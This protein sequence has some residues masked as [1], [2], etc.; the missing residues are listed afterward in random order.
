MAITPQQFAIITKYVALFVALSLLF[1]A[2][3]D[4]EKIYNSVDILNS[5]L[6]VFSNQSKGSFLFGFD[7]IIP[8]LLL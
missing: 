8:I 4:F 7:S 1:T 6:C 3:L 2:V 5:Q